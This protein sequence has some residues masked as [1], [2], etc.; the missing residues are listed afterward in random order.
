MQHS[1]VSDLVW[2]YGFF[3]LIILDY[4]REKSWTENV[5]LLP[6]LIAP[7]LSRGFLFVGQ[8]TA[9]CE[10]KYW[11]VSNESI[12]AAR[13]Q[14]PLFLLQRKLASQMSTCILL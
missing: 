13:W 2:F 9:S 5:R 14:L 7:P 8:H 12:A 11:K 6:N 1:A 10:A 3:A 4:E